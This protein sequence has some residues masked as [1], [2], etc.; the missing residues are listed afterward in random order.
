MVQLLVSKEGWDSQMLATLQ[1]SL[2]HF[3]CYGYGQLKWIQI[4]T[5]IQMAGDLVQNS[6]S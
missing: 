3:H 2:Y 4:K 1:P 5:S 6:S